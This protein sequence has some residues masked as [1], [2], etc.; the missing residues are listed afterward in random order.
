MLRK[1]SLIAKSDEGTVPTDQR[2]S[3]GTLPSRE[4]FQSVAMAIT[5]ILL[6]IL[7]VQ[8]VADPEN[9]W[10]DGDHGQGT[11]FE[12]YPGYCIFNL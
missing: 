12:A 8:S 7:N 6:Q 11:V 2:W 3:V 5:R 4:D 10:E 9:K 1:L